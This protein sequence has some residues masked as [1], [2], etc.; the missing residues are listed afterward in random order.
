MS[1]RDAS[2]GRW[3]EGRTIG[4]PFGIG[5]GVAGL[6]AGFL[7]SVVA[8]GSY[9]ALVHLPAG[10]TTYGTDVVSLLVLWTGLVGAVVT[11]TRLHAP[12]RKGTGPG[13]IA[14]AGAGHLCAAGRGS[15]TGSVVQD[16]GLRLRPWPDIPLGL[17]A[18]VGAQLLLVPL[19]E[20]PLMPFVH[21]LSERLGHPTTQL[22][23]STSGAGLVVLSILVCAGS[24]LVEELFFRGLV[25]RALLGRLEH[26]GQRLAPALSIVLSG[27]VFALA[28]FEALQLIGLAGFGIV[29]GYLAFRTGRL[30]SSI[31]A[32]VAFNSTTV[33]WY[34]VHH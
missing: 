13:G 23:G 32:H 33:I 5:E 20:A 8:V 27:L 28:H 10:A 16:F 4:N 29:L 15:G 6:L 21:H 24:P 11:A 31:V 26:L 12:A 30:G 1:D 22:L 34:V 17:V 19:L 14:P 25:L 2:S 3:R 7:A 18:G 9:A